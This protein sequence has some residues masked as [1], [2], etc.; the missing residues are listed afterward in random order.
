MSS[1][2]D[3]EVHFLFQR[4]SVVVQRFNGVMLHDSFCVEDQPDRWSFQSSLILFNF[5]NH[6]RELSTEGLKK[7]NNNNNNNN[8]RRYRLSANSSFTTPH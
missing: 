7:N 6:L 4:V 8:I 3:R 5:F 1:G 2:D